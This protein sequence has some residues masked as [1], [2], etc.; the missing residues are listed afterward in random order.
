MKATDGGEVVPMKR[1]RAVALVEEVL[2]RLVEGQK[3]RPLN[4]VREVYV[5]GSF[6]RGALE[7]GDVDLDVEFDKDWAWSSAAVDA[8]SAGRD[9]YLPLRRPLVGGKRSVQFMFNGHEAADF[10]MT[11]LWRRGDDLSTALERLYEIKENPA[12][13]RAERHAML[14]QFEGLD[15]WLNRFYREHFIAAIDSG[16]IAVERLSLPEAAVRHLQHP[17][18]EE[19]LWNRWS[20]TSPLRRSAGAV[21]A[22]YIDRGIDPELMNLH[23]EKVTLGKK[24]YYY[25]GFELRYLRSMQWAFAEDGGRE[26]I[27]VVHP[28]KRGEIHALRFLPVSAE[29]FSALDWLRG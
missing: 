9:P 12:A 15:K 19:H 26:W 23:G 13:G 27:E 11:L 3:E 28:V 8:M 20:E 16:A 10:P 4:L 29:R 7:P 22:Y 25:A 14:P 17:V 21:F 6:A 5:F 18:V 1:S 24:P 2:G